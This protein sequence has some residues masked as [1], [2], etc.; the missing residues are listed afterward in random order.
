MTNMFIPRSAESHPPPSEQGAPGMRKE[1]S[2]MVG[3]QHTKVMRLVQEHPSHGL[4]H[5]PPNPP[6]RLVLA[7]RIG[8][9]VGRLHDHSNS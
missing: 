9:L 3:A 8:V 4:V 2:A 5:R 7:A 6:R 1:A